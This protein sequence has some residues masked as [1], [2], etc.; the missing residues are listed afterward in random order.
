MRSILT[1]GLVATLAIF[2]G[3]SVIQ[4]QTAPTQTCSARTLHGTYVFRSQGTFPDGSPGVFVGTQTFDGVGLVQSSNTGS[5]GGFIIKDSG[6]LTYTVNS[7]CTGT[8]TLVLP[9]MTI[10][11]DI[12][13]ADNGKK[14]LAVIANPGFVF[15]AEYTKQ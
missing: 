5:I 1:F 9:Q 4:A 12:F 13:I 3:S 11:W 10:N 14:I 6:T 2:M 8:L 15:S 7:D